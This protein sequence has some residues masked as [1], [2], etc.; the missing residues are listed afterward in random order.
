[1]K[2]CGSCVEGYGAAQIIYNGPLSA[3]MKNERTEETK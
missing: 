3:S 2:V 1:M